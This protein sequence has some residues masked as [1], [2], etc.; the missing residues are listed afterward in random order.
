MTA[1]R[2][3]PGKPLTFLFLKDCPNDISLEGHHSY[4][5]WFDAL[6]HADGPVACIVE[7][8]PLK[9]NTILLAKDVS[10]EIRRLACD[11]SERALTASRITTKACWSAIDIARQFSEG[12]VSAAQLKEAEESARVVATDV[13]R[14]TAWD[15]TLLNAAAAVKNVFLFAT[16]TGDWMKTREVAKQEFNSLLHT[17]C[18]DELDPSS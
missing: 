6:M 11:W 12:T 1:P 3:Q 13:V 10:I 4:A 7:N 9:P 8:S 2:M 14:H 16:K 5:T 15:V 18:N 17:I